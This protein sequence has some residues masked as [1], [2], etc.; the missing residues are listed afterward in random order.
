MPNGNLHKRI[1]VLD[2]HNGAENQ[3]VR[4]IL[5]I[6]DRYALLHGLDLEVHLFDVRRTSAVPDTSYDAY[7]STG[8]PG[9]PLASEGSAWEHS[10]FSLI[11]ALEAWNLAALGPPK[12]GFF[13]CH[14]FQLLCRHYGLGK[15]CRRQSPSFG[16]YP[17]HLTGVG[18]RD[19][20]FRDLA[21]PF[22]VVDSREWQV[23]GVD[24][25]R[26]R[27]LGADVLALEK[28]RPHVALERAL[29]AVRFSPWFIGT[30]FHPEADPDK[31]SVYL[32]DGQK[33]R[34]VTGTLGERKYEGML[35]GLQDRGALAVTRHR[36][37]PGFL[38]EALNVPSP[39]IASRGG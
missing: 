29:M 38:D 20:L 8:G 9:S 7:I 23:T 37:L 32:E 11:R 30:Q 31:L 36:L 27:E 3:G 15:V 5:D 26:A 4:S 25:A 1:A 21:D 10:Y 6:L 18:R 17:V 12:K 2:L 35:R 22:M 28:I 14:S 19:P 34:E 24:E 13:I 39:D 33:K 16:V